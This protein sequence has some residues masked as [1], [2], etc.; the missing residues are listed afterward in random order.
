MAYQRLHLPLMSSA[1]P[2]DLAPP[3]L[4][5]ATDFDAFA[6]RTAA[7]HQLDGI[8][9]DFRSRL[10]EDDRKIERYAAVVDEIVSGMVALMQAW[11]SPDPEE[12][13][14]SLLA[15]ERE[16]QARAADVKKRAAA[17]LRSLA[18]GRLYATPFLNEVRDELVARA[19]RMAE[20]HRDARWRLMRVRAEHLPSKGVG[21]IHG[22]P[23]NLD[24]YA[25]TV[26]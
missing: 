18:P 19:C 25:K 7:Q 20:L 3:A 16:E 14:Q 24:E 5:S 26:G 12:L 8:R 1:V 9:T 11:R 10:A 2:K 13:I 4:L 21:P 22:E 17:G 15:S 6:L 23:T